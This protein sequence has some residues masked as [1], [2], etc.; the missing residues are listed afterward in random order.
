VMTGPA[1]P[2]TMSLPWGL[3]RLLGGITFSLGLVLV[4]VG[5]AELFTGNTLMV[6]AWANG[7]IRSTQLLRNWGLVFLGNTIGALGTALLVFFSGQWRFAAGSVGLTALATAQ[8]KCALD[9]LEALL[10]G[11]LCNTLVCLA[12]WLSFSARS[13]ADRVLVIVPP[14]A[15]FVAAGLEHSIANLYLVP[16]GWLIRTF[17]P[18]TYWTTVGK[19][20]ADYPA[21]TIPTFLLHNLLPVTAGNVIGGAGLVGAVYYFVYLRR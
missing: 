2:A 5:G 21:L 9:P 10:L 6:L 16:L 7:K 3:N 18:D 14:I 8:A 1:G 4:I 15:A 20:A 19:Q 11:V 13:S 17:A 12:V